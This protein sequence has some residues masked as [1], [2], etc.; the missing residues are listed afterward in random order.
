[1]PKAACLEPGGSLHLFSAEG[2]RALEGGTQH[3]W[4]QAV[5]TAV[6]PLAQRHADRLAQPQPWWRLAW[7]R[8][9]AHAAC[10]PLHGGRV[11]RGGWQLTA[12]LRAHPPNLNWVI[13]A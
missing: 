6:G 1:M 12:S 8:R 7:P 4:A 3:A 5:R 10:R 11:V 9:R 2:G 13:P